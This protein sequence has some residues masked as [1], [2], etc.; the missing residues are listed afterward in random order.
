[1]YTFIKIHEFA[2]NICVNATQ[3]Y[4]FSYFIYKN[5]KIVLNHAEYILDNIDYSSLNISFFDDKN[6]LIKILDTDENDFIT[7]LEFEF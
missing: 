7:F 5:N 2:N 1:M 6:N 4:Y 3:N